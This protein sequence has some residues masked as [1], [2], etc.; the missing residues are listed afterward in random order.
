MRDGENCFFLL[1]PRCTIILCIYTTTH[2]E[3]ITRH[4][5][6]A[7]VD[8]RPPPF[9]FGVVAFPQHDDPVTV[10][11]SQLVL[12]VRLVPEN[13]VH[14]AVVHYSQFLLDTC[15]NENSF[16]TIVDIVFPLTFYTDVPRSFS[17]KTK[18][19]GP[20]CCTNIVYVRPRILE[21]ISEKTFRRVQTQ[22]V[23]V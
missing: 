6:F 16:I 21:T 4:V 18:L 19:H 22:R 12:V 13:R 1:P 14:H 17:K 5:S 10:V 15:A 8:P 11:E 2:P 7:V 20:Y 3:Q 9:P 23:L